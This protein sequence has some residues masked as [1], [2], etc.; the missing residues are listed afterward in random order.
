MSQQWHGGGQGGACCEGWTTP[1]ATTTPSPAASACRLLLRPLLLCLGRQLAGFQPPIFVTHDV[2]GHLLADSH[3]R[4]GLRH[5]PVLQV[6]SFVAARVILAISLLAGNNAL[7]GDRNPPPLPSKGELMRSLA[8]T[9]FTSGMNLYHIIAPQ[10]VQPSC[11][12]VDGS[13]KPTCTMKPAEWQSS[14]TTPAR[15]HSLL[16]VDVDLQVICCLGTPLKR[17]TAA[18]DVLA[19][20][21]VNAITTY[22][23]LVRSL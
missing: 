13:L 9:L 18:Q 21:A 8:D 16:Y 17:M 6:A 15:Q 3:D 2:H 1:A 12:R 22:A 14:I 4:V 20:S 23:R 7:L 19:C 5:K 11:T 10:C